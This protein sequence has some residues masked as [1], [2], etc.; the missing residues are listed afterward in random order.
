MVDIAGFLS[1]S[2]K[3]MYAFHKPSWSELK[4]TAF[5]TGMGMLLIGLLGTVIYMSGHLLTF[6]SGLLG[7]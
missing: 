2:K 1:Q 3:V 7:H 5:V 4:Q 6:I